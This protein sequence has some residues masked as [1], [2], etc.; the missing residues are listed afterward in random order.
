MLLSMFLAP[1]SR[2]HTVQDAETLLT[3]ESDGFGPEFVFRAVSPL[4]CCPD[5]II[6]L[7]IDKECDEK[8]LQEVVP[9]VLRKIFGELAGG[10]VCPSA[11]PA[12]ASNP[13]KKH[14]SNVH[15]AATRK[16]TNGLLLKSDA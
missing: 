2:P 5:F 7:T 15:R 4:R 13:R 6:D 1:V 11:L 9:R 16:D 14:G 3:T 10:F 12:R 8:I